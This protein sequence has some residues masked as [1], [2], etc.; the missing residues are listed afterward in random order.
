MFFDPGT[1]TET[2][3]DL[4]ALDSLIAWLE[5]QPANRTYCYTD[6]GHCLIGQYLEQTL[7]EPVSVGPLEYQTR[8]LLGTEADIRLPRSWNHVA[9]VWPHNFGAALER[10]RQLV[11]KAY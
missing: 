4:L 10:A 2:K 11:A 3:T 9:S 5:K 6:N 1:K 7:G 8:A